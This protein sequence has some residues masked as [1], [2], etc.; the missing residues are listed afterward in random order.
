[1]TTTTTD[2][3]SLDT[4]YECA[5]CGEQT[6]DRR[7]PD[8]N[9]F[10]RRLGPGGHCPSCDELVLLED[11]ITTQPA[12]S[13]TGTYTDNLTSS[14]RR[15]VVEL[16]QKTNA[17]RK[18]QIVPF[19]SGAEVRNRFVHALEVR[20]YALL[21]ARAIG[22]RDP[23]ALSLIAECALLHDIGHPPFGHVGERVLDRLARTEGGFESNAHTVHLLLSDVRFSPEV[24]VHSVKHTDV[25]PTFEANPR[26]LRKGTY[27]CDQPEL[28]RQRLNGQYSPLVHS[29]VDVADTL[30]NAAFD[31]VDIA[32]VGGLKL[33][34][35]RRPRRRLHLVGSGDAFQW[36]RQAGSLP[37][38][39]GQ[40]H[41]QVRRWIDAVSVAHRHAAAGPLKI[42]QVVQAEVE[43]L[44]MAARELF[45]DSTLNATFDAV[46]ATT[47]ERAWQQLIDARST[48]TV[49]PPCGCRPAPVAHAIQP[50]SEQTVAEL[51]GTG[52]LFAALF[53]NEKWWPL[54]QSSTPIRE[55][56]S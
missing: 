24:V 52:H 42:P 39:H 43:S 3:A 16:L 18:T 53:P 33:I 45:I 28:C 15:H 41:R 17:A 55:A 34:R 13:T 10:T 27:E 48:L 20:S 23:M 8:C 46:I 7:C 47:L 54:G 30:T 44:T 32:T 4:V 36:I 38:A 2:S 50:M 19:V 21:L 1:M 26:S 29:I 6:T 49:S 12:R 31:L 11:M 51:A 37:D 5:E 35:Q 14:P 9:L 40:A 22:L 25:I 56:T